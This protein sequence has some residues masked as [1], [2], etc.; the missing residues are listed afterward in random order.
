MA[1]FIR[2]FFVR[3]VVGDT[4]YA[5]RKDVF[6]VACEA[7][8]ASVTSPRMHAYVLRH[9]AI[10][11]VIFGYKHHTKSYVRNT[12]ISRS[13]QPLGCLLLVYTGAILRTAGRNAREQIPLDVR[14]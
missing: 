2:L 3:E 12:M 13:L 4:T 7:L 1:I 11:K 14:T 9:H 6:P 8:R 5:R 10:K